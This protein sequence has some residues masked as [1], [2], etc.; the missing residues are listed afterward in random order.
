MITTE[1][2]ASDALTFD[3][4]FF[5]QKIDPRTVLGNPIHFNFSFFTS[6]VELKCFDRS[7]WK[8]GLVHGTVTAVHVDILVGEGGIL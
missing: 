1:A 7:P 8:S 4:P 5:P 2:T 6:E 3:F